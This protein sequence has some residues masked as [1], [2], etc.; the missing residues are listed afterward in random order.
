MR[1]PTS[2]R[3][4]HR[5]TEAAGQAAAQLKRLLA[6]VPRIANGEEHSLAAIAAML[7]VDTKTVVHDLMSVGERY[8][9]PGGFVEGL[10]VFIDAERALVRTNHF[11][12]PMR[13][14]TAELHA[15][16][17]GL[18][19]LRGER[20]PSEW[21]AIDRARER[22]REVAA[23]LPGESPAESF[24]AAAAEMA[25][26]AHLA[27][28]RRALLARRKLRIAY[29]RASSAAARERVV[30]PYRLILAGPVW[31]L[32]ARCERSK[33]I[34]VFRVDRIEQA[35]P[36]DETFAAPDLTA[37]DA[38]LTRGP[39]FVSQAPVTL[40][41]RFSPRIARWIEEH[42]QGTIEPDGSYVV[43][44]R[45]A[46]IDWAVRHVLQYGPE[47]AIVDPPEARQAIRA[48]LATMLET[49]GV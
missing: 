18:A 14:T 17:L 5:V 41:V 19:M 3:A 44:Y 48:R 10:Q 1:R 40:R 42:E 8:D 11:L 25:D 9:V 38:Q 47:A 39:V 2:S 35:D 15:L 4:R 45:L 22:I 13:L 49:C 29:R 31:Y 6:L 7:G 30:W 21:A 46:D 36:L 43:E 26:G 37:L 23:R 12:R 27:T 32:V 28:V 20:A 34:R 33:G 24:Y 16:D